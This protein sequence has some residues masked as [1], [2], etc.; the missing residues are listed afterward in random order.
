M[1]LSPECT[2]GRRHG[3]I[4]VQSLSRHNEPKALWRQNSTASDVSGKCRLSPSVTRLRPAKTAKRIEVLF[5]AKT[6]DG[7]RNI[8]LDGCFRSSCGEEE[9]VEKF[10]PIVQ[11]RN[12]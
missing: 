8:V 9:G 12:G 7:P 3:G 10:S 11:H 4:R 6:L 2:F 5:G 1:L